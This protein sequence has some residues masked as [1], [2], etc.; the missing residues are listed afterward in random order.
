MSPDQLRKSRSLETIKLVEPLKMSEKPITLPDPRL[1]DGEELLIVGLKKR[2]DDGASNLM[3]AQWRE[4]G[5][6]IGN[7]EN[8]R[9]NV[10]YGV[11]CNSD[12]NGNID[13][14]TGVEV[15]DFSDTS[16][17]L[18]H[19]RVPRQT[20]AVFQHS[21]HVSDIRRTRKTILPDRRDALLV[22]T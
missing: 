9:G 2:Y 4:F 15:T 7:I 1:V 14:V 13:Y 12:E 21:G 18:A 11:L 6:H 3:P 22:H 17:S 20:Y 5:P 19:I 8:Q 10:A 16:K